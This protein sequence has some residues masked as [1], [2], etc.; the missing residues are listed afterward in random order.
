MIKISLPFFSVKVSF[1]FMS[2]DNEKRKCVPLCTF[3]LKHYLCMCSV[4]NGYYWSTGDY[5]SLAKL[6]PNRNAC[7][8]QY[9]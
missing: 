1:V 3:K 7:N 8:Y 5:R 6:I 2:D 9:Q 4:L